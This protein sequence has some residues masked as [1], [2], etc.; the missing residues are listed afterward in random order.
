K[1]FGEERFVLAFDI[2]MINTVPIVMTHAWQQVSD[3]TLWSVLKKYDGRL[4]MLCT[5]ISRDGTLTGPNIS[6]YQECGKKFPNFNWIASGGVS[7][8]HDI[9]QLQ[10][11][12]SAVVV[13]KA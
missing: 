10:P 13:G 1:K 3:L 4:S 7:S 2:K 8:L 11:T 9:K 12:V 5:D 6:F